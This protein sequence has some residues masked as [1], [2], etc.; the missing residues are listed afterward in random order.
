MKT[1]IDIPDEEL[2]QAIRF[3]GAK[4]KKDAVVFALKDF[5]RRQRLAM[6]AKMLGTFN[7]F[8]TPDELKVMREDE[9]WGKIK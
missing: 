2:R 5:N 3:T 8:M 7:D 6:L 9:K 1:T 4:T